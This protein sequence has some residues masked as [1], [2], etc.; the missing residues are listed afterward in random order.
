MVVLGDAD[1]DAGGRNNTCP[2]RLVPASVALYRTQ[3]VPQCCDRQ[4]DIQTRTHTY[5]HTLSKVN[6]RRDDDD[7]D[8]GNGDEDGVVGVKDCCGREV[9][10]AQILT[11]D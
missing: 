9:C 8:G 6:Y 11:R 5:I 2:T 3:E 1:G 7:D 4:V 10:R